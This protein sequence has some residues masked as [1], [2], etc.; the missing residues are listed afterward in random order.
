M[1]IKYTK[2]DYKLV[3][4]DKIAVISGK[5]FHIAVPILVFILVSLVLPY[6]EAIYTWGVRKLQFMLF[7]VS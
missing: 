5:V 6:F 1:T 4:K 7:K 3:I 2:A